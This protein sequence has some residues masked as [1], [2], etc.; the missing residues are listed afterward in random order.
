MNKP[1]FTRVP[2]EA[3]LQQRP[4][5]PEWEEVASTGIDFLWRWP[6]NMSNHV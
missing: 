3:F 2:R 1:T 4:D 5:A 6:G